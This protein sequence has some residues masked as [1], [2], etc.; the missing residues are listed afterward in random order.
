MKFVE[1]LLAQ[2]RWD[3][4]RAIGYRARAECEAKRRLIDEIFEYEAGIDAAR[5]CGHEPEQIQAGV[6][7]FIQPE[8]IAALRIM[9]VPYTNREGYREEW[10]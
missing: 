10:N 9:A 5:G 2:I 7:A 3:E 8:G 6:C 1:F 4:E